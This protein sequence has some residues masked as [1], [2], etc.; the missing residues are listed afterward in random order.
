MYACVLTVGHFVC[1]PPPKISYICAEE[2]TLGFQG[3]VR[4]YIWDY[5]GVGSDVL[6]RATFFFMDFLLV[7]FFLKES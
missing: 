6:P 3:E 2:G 5:G 1:V 4:Y 7:A